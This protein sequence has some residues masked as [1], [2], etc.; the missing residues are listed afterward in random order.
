MASGITV[1]GLALSPIAANASATLSA[2]GQAWGATYGSAEANA[3]AQAHSSL[4]ALASSRGYSTCINVTYSD[5]LYYVVPGGGGDV[6]NSTATGLCGNQVFHPGAT[7]SASGQAWGATYGSA[8]ANAEAQ[9]HSSLL[10]L[11]SSRG[12]STCINVTYSDSLYYVVPG[13]GGDVFNS[14]ATG[15]CGN[16]VF[17]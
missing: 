14:T 3:E 6:F 8:E 1:L 5:S 4:L 16:Q 10:A 2:S 11:A 13:G 7:L 15:L 9:A 12:Y 17:Q